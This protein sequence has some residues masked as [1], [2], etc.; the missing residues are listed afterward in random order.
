MG[1]T[2]HQLWGPISKV[3]TWRSLHWSLIQKWIGQTLYRTRRNQGENSVSR[4]LSRLLP[5]EVTKLVRQEYTFN[6]KATQEC[7]D[8]NVLNYLVFFFLSLNSVLFPLKCPKHPLRCKGIKCIPQN[9]QEVWQNKMQQ[10]FAS[11][12]IVEVLAIWA[13]SGK[14]EIAV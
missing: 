1:L 10:G 9:T 14:G 7:I 3:T 11:G 5:Q 8:F 13:S 6:S 4:S 2:F 12:C